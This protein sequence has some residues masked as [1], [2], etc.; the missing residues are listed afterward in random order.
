MKDYY[1]IINDPFLKNIQLKD[2]QSLINITTLRYKQDKK[3]IDDI[4]NKSSYKYLNKKEIEI[5]KKFNK[6][7]NDYDDNLNLQYLKNILNDLLKLSND[8]ILAYCIKNGV[9]GLINVDI[10][11]YNGKKY[12]YFTQG[13]NNVSNNSFYK[14]AIFLEKYKNIITEILS[15]VLNIDK[16]TNIDM[17][18]NNIIK[19]E[20]ELE[21]KKL[22]N[23]EKR[24]ILGVFNKY[25]ISDINLKN[26]NIS[27]LINLLLDKNIDSNTYIYFDTELPNKY[28][29]ELDNNF[30]ESYFRYYIIWCILLELSSVTIGFLY[31][32]A[33]E[34][35]KILK[36]IKK[37][38]DFE[39]KI[40]FINNQLIGHLI[41]KEYFIN[42]DSNVKTEI[43][44]YIEYIKKSFRE[45]L[46]NNTWMDNITKQTAIKKL[47]NIKS[48]IYETKLIDFNSM[49]ELTNLY[50]KNVHIINEYLLK[51]KIDE[52]Y[53]TDRYFYGN[54]YNINAFYET[55]T[56][57]IIFPYGIL[58]PPYYY[59]TDINNIN[60]LENI[61]YNFGAI[62]SVIGHEI[63]HGFDDQGRLF[64]EN[65]YLKNWWQPE[66][67]K[68]YIEQ[69]KKIGKIYKE[70]GINPDLT[71]G[72][73]IADIGGVRISL[74][75]YKILL[76]EKGKELDDKLL[77]NFLKGWTMVWRGKTTKEE[78][79]N[80]LLNDPHS[81]IRFRVN[82]PLNN[83]EET[84]NNT[85]IIE[86]W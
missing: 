79:A 18:V 8:E 12:L 17:I 19:Y 70:H 15:K 56:N 26:I 58:K 68:K 74:S 45:R 62:G 76:K 54:T 31:D 60:N 37:K 52:L 55:T 57:E 73:N 38:M 41:S 14:D 39:K 2:D 34:L 53:M 32:K 82:I 63:I 25:K 21:K 49:A 20:I 47:N 43:Q 40:Y 6:S 67:E 75:A 44:Q 23:S 36:G 50:Y 24:N 28:Y 85:E 65:G 48:D 80:R 59:N 5:I 69:T 35:V 10:L 71:M 51:K 4:I 86:I 27:K 33:F 42:I 78:A 81:P 61:A 64:D 1:N 84:K 11:L 29:E 13:K 77:S 72:E 7:I 9:G 46:I 30:S 83:L 22:L 66:S 3:L 16:G